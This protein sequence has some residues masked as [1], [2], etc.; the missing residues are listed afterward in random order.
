[1][2][3][4]LNQATTGFS[5][6]RVRLR[7]SILVST[8][9]HAALL[10]MLVFS[11]Q[12]MPQ[13]AIPVPFG[14]RP[15][16]PSVVEIVEW[17]PNPSL[18]DTEGVVVQ[19]EKMR[20][21]EKRLPRPNPIAADASGTAT[22]ESANATSAPASQNLGETNGQEIIEAKHRYLYELRV[23]IEEKK[24]YPKMAKLRGETGSVIVSAEITKD[25]ILQ[26][27]AIEK[28]SDFAS[29][30]EAALSLVSAFSKFKP[31]PEGVGPES[32][33]VSIPIEYSL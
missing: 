31:L 1:M 13:Q 17:M 3:G 33:R 16:Q 21:T 11:S 18:P 25:G 32:L 19:K 7:S 24:T 26:A 8:A 5:F 2:D 22:N 30:N 9:V 10:L 12:L 14:S 28:P 29:L 23:S 27:V 15:S 20:P 4:I 6:E